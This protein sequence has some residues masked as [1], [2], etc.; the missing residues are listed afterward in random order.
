MT[1][2]TAEV[3]EKVFTMRANRVTTRKISE[4]T[5]LNYSAV[6]RI[7]R[8][9]QVPLPI[10]YV[11]KI[12]GNIPCEKMLP[13]LYKQAKL[14]STMSDGRYQ[15]DELVNGALLVGKMQKITNIKYASRC[16]KYAIMDYIRSQEGR[17]ISNKHSHKLNIVSINK[18]ISGTDS[19]S[20]GDRLVS[21]ENTQTAVENKD[22]WEFIFHKIKMKYRSKMILLDRYEKEMTFEQIGF[23]YDMSV[24]NVSLIMSST[25]DLI[26]RHFHVSND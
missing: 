16:A 26:R 20:V 25:L 8:E 23:K 17:D 12:E 9:Y 7:I 6:V 21:R 18:T 1:N 15:I 24:A 13:A 4:Q 19:I 10:K 5:G 22:L 2:I 11:D 14:Y 3:R